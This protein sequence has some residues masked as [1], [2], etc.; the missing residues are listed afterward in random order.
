MELILDCREKGLIERMPE[1]A[2]QQLV[3]G[4]AVLKYE[5][6]ELVLIERKTIADFAASITDGRYREQSERLTACEIP[7]HNI[8]YLIEGS[9]K[10]Y[11]L[12]LPKS[13]LLA[14]M[15]SLLYGK[16][17]SVVRTESLEDTVEFIESMCKKLDKEKG[18][19]QPK[20]GACEIKKQK[21]D[22]ITPETI[23]AFMISQIPSVSSAT[24]KALLAAY[25]TVFELITALKA[26]PECLATLKVG[27]RSISKSTVA[28]IK[29]YLLR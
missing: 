17:F 3:L 7:N 22:R 2:V 27:Q 10:H 29:T 20:E 8:L 4:D 18:Y 24:A 15:T 13:T 9:L 23:D 28:T 5:G 14:T 26:D 16:G 11:K 25:P 21:R 1:A 19:A 12:S 6:K